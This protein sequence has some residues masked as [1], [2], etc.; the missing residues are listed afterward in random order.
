MKLRF[1]CHEQQ[2]VEAIHILG[3]LCPKYQED[4]AQD[5]ILRTSTWTPVVTTLKALH[6]FGYL[7]SQF[8]DLAVF[9]S[10]SPECCSLALGRLSHSTHVSAQRVIFT[11]GLP[12]LILNSLSF[13]HNSLL[14]H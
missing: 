14:C 11:R 4:T 6:V 13:A 7:P 10:L 1:C 3:I 9:I 12:D 8:W 2:E 5:G